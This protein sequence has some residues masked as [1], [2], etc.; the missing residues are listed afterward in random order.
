MTELATLLGNTPQI[1]TLDHGS[2]IIWFRLERQ[3]RKSF[4]SDRSFGA[5]IVNHFQELGVGCKSFDSDFR[6]RRR[7]RCSFLWFRIKQ[8]FGASIYLS[9]STLSKEKRRLEPDFCLNMKPNWN[10]VCKKVSYISLYSLLSSERIQRKQ[11]RKK[12][13]LQNEIR[14]G[15]KLTLE[16]QVNSF[17]RRVTKTAINF[18]VWLLL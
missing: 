9:G 3:V 7:W 17:L 8:S 5:R 2:W 4:D 18:S 11:N 14:W 6:A 16:K 12:G 13:N 15:K 1:R 10:L